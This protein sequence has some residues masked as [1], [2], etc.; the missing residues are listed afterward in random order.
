MNQ[1]L[2]MGISTTQDSSG[3]FRLLPHMWPVL[4]V[5]VICFYVI[6][7]AWIVR[8]IRGIQSRS[9]SD[10]KP[11]TGQADLSAEPLGKTR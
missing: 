7:G 10:Q 11:L 4:V 8:K 9:P 5:P 3:Y 2:A 6:L 1:F